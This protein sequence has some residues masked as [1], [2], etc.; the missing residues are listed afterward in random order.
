MSK[1]FI[2][3]FIIGSLSACGGSNTEGTTDGLPVTTED[4]IAG[5]RN[6]ANAPGPASSISAGSE[7]GYLT[8]Y[9]AYSDRNRDSTGSGISPGSAETR[10]EDVK[11]W[12][13]DN[14]TRVVYLDVNNPKKE[15]FEFDSDGKGGTPNA[16]G[17]AVSYKY[18]EKAGRAGELDLIRSDSWFMEGRLNSDR[19]DTNI[20]PR[21]VFFA[22]WPINGSDLPSGGTA[23]YTAQ[24]SAVLFLNDGRRLFGGEVD[25]TADFG[26]RTLNGRVFD[27]TW[28]TSVGGFQGLYATVEVNNA[29]IDNANA[30]ISGADNVNFTFFNDFR[31]TEQLETGQTHVDFDGPPTVTSAELV[32]EFVGTSPISVI[33][34]FGMD[35]TISRGG[36][37]EAFAAHG[38]FRGTGQVDKC[39]QAPEDQPLRWG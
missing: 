13:E 30:T 5:S 2:M 18:V 9:S 34:A 28:Q 39:F 21:R 19:D 3:L 11:L 8:A 22:G 6:Q 7:M 33:G 26:A 17:N 20:G 35:G 12:L 10:I 16:A 24:E 36:Q 15:F 1:Y 31:S 37:S 32:G 27:N 29:Q 38:V 4:P 25:L 14:G 23:T